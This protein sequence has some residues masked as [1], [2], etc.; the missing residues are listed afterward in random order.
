MQNSADWDCFKT[1]ILLETLRARSQHWG[2]FCAYLEVV[3]LFFISLDA[4]LQMDGLSALDLWDMV[5]EVL[6]STNNTKTPNIPCVW[7]QL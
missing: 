6:H 4:G 7:K 3:Q 2:K 1:Q 5:I